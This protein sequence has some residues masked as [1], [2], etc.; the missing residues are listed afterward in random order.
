MN[1]EANPRT[2]SPHQLVRIVALSVGSSGVS[3]KASKIAA[4]SRLN[5]YAAR[6]TIVSVKSLVRQP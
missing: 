5:F 2:P 1:L 6:N 4:D 3:G